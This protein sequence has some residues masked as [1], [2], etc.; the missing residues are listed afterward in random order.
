MRVVVPLFTPAF[1]RPTKKFACVA[2]SVQLKLF[3][4]QPGV[5]SRQQFFHACL[6][7]FRISWRANFCVIIEVHKDISFRASHGSLR[8]GILPVARFTAL[9]PCSHASRPFF[10]CILAIA[11]R[12]QHLGTMQTTVNKVGSH[13]HQAR[14]LDGIRTHQRDLIFAQHRNELWHDKTGMTN[15]QGMAKR[16]VSIC[17]QKRSS[18]DHPIVILPQLN[19]LACVSRQ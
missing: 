18:L 1:M 15:F 4:S 17:L 19:R 16:S 6:Q 2:D 3:A 9:R 8:A 12:I 5:H 10:N 7:P 13:I 11:A 14:P